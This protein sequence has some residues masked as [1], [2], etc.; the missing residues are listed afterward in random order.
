LFE[1]H[2]RDVTCV[3]RGAAF[4]LGHAMADGGGWID[5]WVVPTTEGVALLPGFLVHPA[6]ATEPMREILAS[7]ELPFDD[8]LDELLAMRH[9]LASRSRMKARQVYRLATPR[10][11]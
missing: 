10:A 3:V 1:V 6:E 7:H 9:R 2:A 11:P 5:G 4:R 8:V